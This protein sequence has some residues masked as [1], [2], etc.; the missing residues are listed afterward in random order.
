MHDDNTLDIDYCRVCY[1]QQ[2]PSQLVSHTW[3]DF[4]PLYNR[5]E[6]QVPPSDREHF[7]CRQCFPR[8]GHLPYNCHV[9]NLSLGCAHRYP[10]ALRELSP[11]EERLIGIYRP[12]GWITKLTIEVE[13]WTSGKYRKHKRGHITV[14]PNDVQGTA[15]NVLPHP[16][17]DE[18]ERLHVCFVGPRRPMPSDLGFMLSVRPV[19]LRRAL[20]WLRANNPLY[21]DIMIDE[22]NLQTW[23]D[24]CPGTQVPRAIIDQMVAYNLS[25]E[26]EIR[27]GN[28]VPPAER[29]RPDE[30]IRSA[31]EVLR[32]LEDREFDSAVAEAEGNARLGGL[33]ASGRDVDDMDPRH[34]EEELEELKSTGM[35][36]AAGAGEYSPQERLRL[37]RNATLEGGQQRRGRKPTSSNAEGN[38]V[39][40]DDGM[41]PYIISQ[42]GEDPA[43]TND[44][45]FFPKTFPCLFPWGRG[46][47]RPLDSTDADKQDHEAFGSNKPKGF[48]LRRW[49]RVMLQRHGTKLAPS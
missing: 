14:F 24:S 1:L 43:D 19:K 49:A 39:T 37:L 27:T 20:V 15:S 42:R 31:S 16:L 33:R 46:G 23:G 48:D 40:Y 22:R 35:M 34:I 10:D 41:R 21:R 6:T 45:D 47:P 28:Y 36:G 32:S 26:D 25:A 17:L 8:Q 12:C 38:R 3:A 30:P 9:N 11:L 18:L 13:K 2:P 4:E 7:Q 5:I 44:S 29:G